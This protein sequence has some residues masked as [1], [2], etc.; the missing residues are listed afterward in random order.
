MRIAATVITAA[1]VVLPVAPAA[2]SCAEPP[3]TPRPTDYAQAFAGVVE[4]TTNGGGTAEVRVLDVWHGP[5]LPPRVVVVG[6]QLRRGVESSV[7]RTYKRGQSLSRAGSD[8]GS[9]S[10]EG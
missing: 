1:A 7:D 4:R 2:A 5:S 9:Q 6:G 8:G 10:T 3:G